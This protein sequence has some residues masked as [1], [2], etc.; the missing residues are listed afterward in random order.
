MEY[1]NEVKLAS[2]SIERTLLALSEREEDDRKE[3]AKIQKRISDRMGKVYL[4]PLHLS[5]YL[6]KKCV[7]V[8]CVCIEYVF[9]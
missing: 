1:T 6:N 7:C 3:K 4:C 8:E 5:F 9:Y 2:E